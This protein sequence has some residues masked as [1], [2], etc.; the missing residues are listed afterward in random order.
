MLAGSDYDSDE[1]CYDE[2]RDP[3][4]VL[5]A[6]RGDLSAVRREIEAATREGKPWVINS[7]EWVI[8]ATQGVLLGG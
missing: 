2:Q 6:K 8:A 7:G 1:D 4:I 5:A 3:S